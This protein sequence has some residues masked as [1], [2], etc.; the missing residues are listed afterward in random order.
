M[1]AIIKVQCVNIVDLKRMINLD[2]VDLEIRQCST[3]RQS[4]KASKIITYNNF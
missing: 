1:I 3:Y 4:L 2:E